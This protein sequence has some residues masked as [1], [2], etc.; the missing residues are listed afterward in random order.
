MKSKEKRKFKILFYTIGAIFFGGIAWTNEAID[1]ASKIGINTNPAWTFLLTVL[2][3]LI[4]ASLALWEIIIERP[5]RRK[6]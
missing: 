5:K 6:K 4:L 3:M 1:W 2:I